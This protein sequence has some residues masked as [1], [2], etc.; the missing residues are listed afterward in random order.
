[1]DSATIRYIFFLMALLIIVSYFVGAATET[2]SLALGAQR[3]IY[4]LTGRTAS[5]ATSGYATGAGS[6]VVSIG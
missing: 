5:G 6:G 3:L 2:N 1:M 4:A